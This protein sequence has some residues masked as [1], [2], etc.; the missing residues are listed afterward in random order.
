[1]IVAYIDSVKER[2]GFEPVCAELSQQG[3]TIAPST[4]SRAQGVPGLPGSASGGVPGQRV[5]DPASAE[6]GRVRGA[7]AVARGPPGGLHGHHV[8][9]LSRDGAAARGSPWVADSLD[10]RP[11]ESYEVAFVADNPGIWS[12]HCHTLAHAVDGLIAHLMYAGVSTRFTIGGDAANH[13][14]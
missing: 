3:I 11:G 14:E 4:Y 7:E 5:G 10:V 8:T 2:H 12:D 6:L 1:V 13:P 9:V